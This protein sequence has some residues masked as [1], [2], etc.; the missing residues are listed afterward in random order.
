MADLPQLSKDA[1]RILKII[2]D[3]TTIR[4]SNL[5]RE[6]RLKLPSELLD[7]VKELQDKN[8]IEVSGDVSSETTVPFAFFATRPSA[9][10]YIYSVLKRQSL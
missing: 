3:R 1:A 5:M 9:K 6:A 10:E 4:G 8:L 7:P 2:L